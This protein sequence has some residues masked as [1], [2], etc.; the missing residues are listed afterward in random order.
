M[1]TAI[2]LYGKP[3]AGEDARPTM[4]IVGELESYEPSEPYEGRLQ[5]IDSIGKCKVE[6]VES[7]L[8]PDAFAFVDNFTKEVVLRWAAFDIV[9]DS[10]G[11]PNGGFEDGPT[12]TQWKLGPGWSIAGVAETGSFGATY[13][14]QRGTQSIESAPVPYNGQTIAASSRFNQGA[15]SKDNLV[16]RIVLVWCD[17]SGNPLPGGEGVGFTAGNLI[18]GGSGGEWQTSTV[19]ASHPTA[20]MVSIGFSATR[21][22]QNKPAFVD[23]F[24]WNHSWPTGTN[25]VDEEYSVTFKVTD[26]ENQV[27]F[28]S[29]TIGEDSLRLTSIPYGVL[30][31]DSFNV[32]ATMRGAFVM[33]DNTDEIT[34]GATLT[35][36]E[37]REPLKVFSVEADQV[38][39]S[40]VLQSIEMRTPLVA[41]T[42]AAEEINNS[43][44]L[45]AI[46][47]RT[48]LVSFNVSA[49]SVNNGATLTSVVMQ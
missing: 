37:L 36:I 3:L 8:P 34:N 30:V 13:A 41:F 42:V 44:A 47:M 45:T 38:N 15:S 43:A 2:L 14:N 1:S 27:A 6:I 28:W 17:A 21:K 39:N 4:R 9:P 12:T 26:S 48:V 5:I 35:S 33:S 16:G 29:G 40:A 31:V 18:S 22:R 49:D 10:A 7:F 25:V 20:A 32:G 46:E 24:A 19:T 11:V 23:N